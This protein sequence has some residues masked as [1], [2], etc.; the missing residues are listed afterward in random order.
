M[1]ISENTINNFV[2]SCSLRSQPGQQHQAEP[3]FPGAT[4]QEQREHASS[5]I[6]VLAASCNLSHRKCC[7]TQMEAHCGKQEHFGDASLRAMD[8]LVQYT[9]VGS[10]NYA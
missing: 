5:E 1:Y 2:D 3:G 4:A 10:H 8:G 6:K 7:L 9:Q